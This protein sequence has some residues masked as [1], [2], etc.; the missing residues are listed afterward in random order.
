MRSS[1][2]L[3]HITD[4]M[5]SADVIANMLNDNKADTTPEFNI[6]GSTEGF[7]HPFSTVTMKIM[8]NPKA[9]VLLSD[10]PA[11]LP[12]QGMEIFVIR[13][14]DP[15]VD[16]IQIEAR[17][18]PKELPTYLSVETLE[19]GICWYD[20]LYQDCFAVHNRTNTALKV[21]FHVSHQ[22]QNH[23]EVLPKTGFVQV[24]AM[25][26]FTVWFALLGNLTLSFNDFKFD[27]K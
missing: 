9:C 5:L 24:R 3:Q 22:V 21:N 1:N 2:N 11:H 6:F 27:E 23:L 26:H 4:M 16:D 20:R 17:G 19:M 12:G 7:L 15:L 18:Q 25:S 13:F 8:W 14:D 10:K